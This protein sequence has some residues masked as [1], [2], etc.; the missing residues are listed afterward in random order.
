M[1][2]E[3]GKTLYIYLA[4]SCQLLALRFFSLTKLY[5][6]IKFFLARLSCSFYIWS[7]ICFDKFLLLNEKRSSLIHLT[8]LLLFQ[9]GFHFWAS[10]PN[11]SCV[12]VADFVLD[13]VCYMIDRL[14]LHLCVPF[15]AGR[16]ENLAWSS[17]PGID[18]S[19]KSRSFFS[20]YAFRFDPSVKSSKIC[21]LL[22]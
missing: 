12:L 7:F 14:A 19:V 17:L 6:W 8:G 10:F 11:K 3:K 18:L 22:S 2:E 20:M 21:H 1:R 16:R 9:L 13:L 15:P 5:S 4:S